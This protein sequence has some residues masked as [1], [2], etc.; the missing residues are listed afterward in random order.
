MDTDE[1]VV[2]DFSS[3]KKRIKSMI[4]DMMLGW[5]H[6]LW[7]LDIS[8]YTDMPP[9]GTI[10]TANL[11]LTAPSTAVVPIHS[12]ASVYDDCTEME[13]VARAVC[14]DIRDDLSVMFPHLVFEVDAA[15]PSFNEVVPRSVP[16]YFT[17]RRNFHYCHGLPVS[18]SLGCQNIAHGHYS[19]I[20]VTVPVDKVSSEL[21]ELLDTYSGE[22]GCERAPTHYF[23]GGDA[24]RAKYECAPDGYL[25]FSAY[26]YT[27]GRGDFS[28]TLHER[29]DSAVIH[30]VQ[31]ESTVE[32][33]VDYVT[34][35]VLNACEGL[36]ADDIVV[37]VSEGLDKGAVHNP[38]LLM[39]MIHRVQD[40]K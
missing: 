11:S 24:S 16:G 36:T 26:S 2:E 23:I 37:T 25:A 15:E 8:D 21:A 35:Q 13:A 12:L 33:L 28:L 1:A 34:D 9:L 32:N 30:I 10:L 31:E 3:I 22:E 27:T 5:D 19:Q 20:T 29:K 17:Y 4:D 38:E 14:R 39:Q 7:L 40:G 18:S 6:K